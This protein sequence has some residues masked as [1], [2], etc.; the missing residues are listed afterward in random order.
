M[1]LPPTHYNY[2][3][4]HFEFRGSASVRPNLFKCSTDRQRSAVVGWGPRIPIRVLG[5]L[6]FHVWIL[7]SEHP[8][9]IRWKQT[10][11]TPT[12]TDSTPICTAAHQCSFAPS[13]KWTTNPLLLISS[14]LKQV[15]PP[16]PVSNH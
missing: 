3:P 4:F 5:A 14:V 16:E 8:P 9:A 11:N 15:R 13:S 7:Q 6:T 2:S 1:L 12:G 10:R